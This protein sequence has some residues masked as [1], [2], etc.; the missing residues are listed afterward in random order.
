MKTARNIIITGLSCIIIIC[1]LV[2]IFAKAY[3]TPETIEQS[4]KLETKK[5]LKR[6]ITFGAI[7]VSLSG[8][9]KLK[10]ITLQKSL[11]WEKK[12]IIS[13]REIDLNCRILPLMLKKLFIKDIRVIDPDIYLQHAEN[14]PFSLYG[15]QRYKKNNGNHLKIIFLPKAVNV[16][17]GNVHITNFNDNQDMSFGNLSITA[18]NLSL[19]FP[20]QFE[21]SANIT[22]KPQARIVCRGNFHI[23]DKKISAEI[24]ASKFPLST[25]KGYF[26]NHGI[27]VRA[28]ELNLKTFIKTDK[29]TDLSLSGNI[30]LN[31]ATLIIKAASEADGCGVKLSSVN[32]NLSFTSVYN[33]SRRILNISDINGQF[34]MSKYHG[35]GKIGFSGRNSHVNLSLS[36]EKFHIDDLMRKID[37]GCYP[38]IDDLTVSG[39]IGLKV[40]LK[41]RTGRGIL[42]TVSIKLHDN[43]LLYPALG[44]VKPGFTGEISIDRNNISVA[45][46]KIKTKNLSF[47]LAGDI[48]GYSKWPPRSSLRVVSSYINV[49]GLID[50]ESSDP[51]SEIGPFDLSGMFLDGPI[52][53]GS[54]SFFSTRLTNVHGRYMLKDNKFFIKDLNGNIGPGNFNLTTTVDLGIAGLDYFIYLKVNDAPVKSIIKM[55]PSSYYSKHI[56]GT[57]SATCALKGQGTNPQNLID[58]LKGDAFIVLN[59][60]NIKGLNFLPQLSYFM[61]SSDLEKI[62][63][64]KANLDLKLRQAIV[65]IEGAFINPLLELHP[66]GEAGLDSTLDMEATL[67]IS[68]DLFTDSTKLADYLPKE[69]GWVVLP[70]NITGTLQDPEIALKQDTLDYI[71]KDTIPK[72]MMDIFS[73]ETESSAKEL[74]QNL[75][76]QGDEPGDN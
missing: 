62:R 49:D 63:F 41:S 24:Q 55:F 56:E 61:K 34:L 66:S 3:L 39:D 51:S 58:S 4:I 38:V 32:A 17:G 25:L 20:S 21:L 75:Q 68:P 1:I 37:S 11:P 36:S 53:L 59:D 47:T 2:F 69:N 6:D 10:D 12:Q 23:P 5:Y 40:S 15:R 22:G 7:E 9:I 33:K 54:T 16:S 42:P 27:P 67:K 73:G 64:N 30:S 65:D 8:K 52:K 76:L 60:G 26:I 74:L 43:H 14:H 35:K 13:C 31:R 19:F 70:A 50:P 57:I 28:G 71:L 29:K 72:L 18:N 46:F 45:N 44:S 48:S